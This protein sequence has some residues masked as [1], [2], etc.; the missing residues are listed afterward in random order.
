[1]R[2]APPVRLLKPIAGQDPGEG[3]GA[4]PACLERPNKAGVGASDTFHASNLAYGLRE[5]PLIGSLHKG[6]NIR[7]AGH[8][9]DGLDVGDSLQR[10]GKLP[11]LLPPTPPPP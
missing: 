3:L 7:R 2:S 11:H 5:G 6:N 4:A 1:M 8:E 9:V 10:L